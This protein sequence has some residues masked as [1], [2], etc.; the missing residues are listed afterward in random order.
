MA[1]SRKNTDWFFKRLFSSDEFKKDVEPLKIALKEQYGEVYGLFAE[2]GLANF[3][4]TIGKILVVGTITNR[5]RLPEKYL[6]QYLYWGRFEWY[7]RAY[8]TRE[9]LYTEF[10]LILCNTSFVSLYWSWQ[11]VDKDNVS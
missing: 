6:R 8:Y 9:L 4:D 11:I 7:F 10:S 3:K 2:T 5:Y 1:Y